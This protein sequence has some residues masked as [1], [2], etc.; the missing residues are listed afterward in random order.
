MRSPWLAAKPTK[1]LTLPH[2]HHH[3]T[4]PPA[5]S[6]KKIGGAKVRKV[7]GQDK[8]SLVDKGKKEDEKKQSD[9]KAITTSHRQTTAH[10]LSEQNTT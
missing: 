1:L 10:L 7:T 6:G 5:E 8:N 9:A 2:P 3:L 4:S